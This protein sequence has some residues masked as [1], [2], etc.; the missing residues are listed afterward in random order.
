[1]L[2]QVWILS[3]VAARTAIVLIA[4]LAGIRLT[5]R[6]RLG[7]ANLVDVV[8]VL[9]LANAVQN[10][11]TYGSG[12]LSVGL[13]SALVLLLLEKQFGFLASARPWAER[14]L[15]GDPVP[16]VAD[17]RPDRE[18]MRRH[19]VTEDEVMAAARDMGLAEIEQVRLAMLEPNGE[20]SIIPKDR[21]KAV[22]G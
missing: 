7:A 2:D 15:T 3:A 14:L 9:L 1:M 12:L 8:M 21:E 10:A 4:L 19:R 6:R 16:L 17:G 20:I 18:A 22:N 13:V 5:G 11:M